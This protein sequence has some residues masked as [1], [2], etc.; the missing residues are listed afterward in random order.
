MS[1]LENVLLAKAKNIS[2]NAY[3]IFKEQINYK[4]KDR[5]PM[6]ENAIYNIFFEQQNT[7]VDNFCKNIKDT[8]SSEQ[9]SA[10]I[11]KLFCRMSD[12]LDFI[13][14]NNASI[15][16]EYISNEKRIFRKI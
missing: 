2:E 14:E 1:A 15:Y 5:Y 4:L 13:L 6:N 16:E 9:I 12:E 10:Y 8:L 11:L 3:D 7:L